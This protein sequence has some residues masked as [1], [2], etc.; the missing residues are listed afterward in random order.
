[1]HRRGG[2]VKRGEKK[3]RQN[4]FTILSL[5]CNGY[6]FPTEKVKGQRPL[7]GYEKYVYIQEHRWCEDGTNLGGVS[8]CK[9]TSK[10]LRLKIHI[11]N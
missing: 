2:R 4:V 1:M 8:V 6:G 9:K 11:C 7:S 5:K 10:N 3:Q